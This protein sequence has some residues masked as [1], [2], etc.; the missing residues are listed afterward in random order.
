MVD[1]QD[2]H[3]LSTLAYNLYQTT[4]NAENIWDTGMVDTNILN[5]IRVQVI[6]IQKMLD[7]WGNE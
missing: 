3:D 4:N 2:V 6:R 1:R 5:S 7:D